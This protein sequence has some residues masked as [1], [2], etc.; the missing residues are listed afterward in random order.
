MR[1]DGSM[2]PKP[3]REDPG[4]AD[5]RVEELLQELTPVDPPPF[6]R[7]RLLARIRA[8]AREPSWLAWAREP[9]FAWSVATACVVALLVT[10]AYVRFGSSGPIADGG[11]VSVAVAGEPGVDPVVPVD[12]SVVAAGDVDIVAAIYPPVENGVIRLYVDE[13]DVTGLADITNDYVMYS[14]AE[15]LEEGE[16]IVTIEIRDAHGRKLKDVSWLFYTLNGR[17]RAADVDERV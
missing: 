3:D 2:R 13:R 9:R 6:Y 11:D 1:G 17:G 14:P 12:N 16:H 4:V 8:A 5:E 10:V 15:S 7:E